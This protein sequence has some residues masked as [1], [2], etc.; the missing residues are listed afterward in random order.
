MELSELEISSAKTSPNFPNRA[1]FSKKNRPISENEE[2]PDLLE[3]L[4]LEHPNGC[5]PKV[6]A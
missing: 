5:S 1:D 4:F 3:H 6:D 2:I